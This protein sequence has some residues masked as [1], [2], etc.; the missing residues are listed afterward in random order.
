MYDV[1]IVLKYLTS[2]PKPEDVGLKKLSIRI[3]TLICIL[4]GQRSQTI[5]YLTTT[6]VWPTD[7]KIIFPIDSLLKTS[8]PGFHQEPLEFSKYEANPNI[9]PIYNINSYID[10]TK[11]LRGE[12]K[13]LFIC[14]VPPHKLVTPKTIA[15]WVL[16]FLQDSGIDINKFGT[17]STRSAATSKASKLGMSLEE[18][19]KAAGWSNLSTFRRHYKKPITAKENL[20]QRLTR[21]FSCK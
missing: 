16:S 14:F 12:E 1:D 6:F 18:I 3:A 10:R 8:R 2:L 4:S 7:E 11:E 17:H 19:G 13:G 9:C 5:S 20:G 21:D 15:R